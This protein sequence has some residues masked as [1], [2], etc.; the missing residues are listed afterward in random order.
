MQPLDIALDVGI[1]LQLIQVCATQFQDHTGSR[2]RDLGAL[3]QQ[4][5]LSPASG[6]HARPCAGR[7]HRASLSTSVCL[8]SVLR[9]K[10][11]LLTLKWRSSTSLWRFAKTQGCVNHGPVIRQCEVLRLE[12]AEQHSKEGGWVGISEWWLRH[13][14]GDSESCG[15]VSSQL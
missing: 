5:L 3:C 9:Q 11:M 7:G 8:V 15:L 6:H 2:R 12:T 1:D 14:C 13:C 4:H 10:A